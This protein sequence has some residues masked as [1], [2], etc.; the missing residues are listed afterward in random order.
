MKRNSAIAVAAG[1]LSGVLLV[2]AWHGSYLGILLGMMF[3]V[4]CGSVSSPRSSA[5]T[6]P[7]DYTITVTATGTAGT[8]GGNT[9]GHPISFALTVQ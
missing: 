6:P 7:G 2:A 9:L 4:A 1:A 5:G 8:N 3:W